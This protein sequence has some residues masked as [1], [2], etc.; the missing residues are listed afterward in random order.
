MRKS[1]I[2]FSIILI[3]LSFCGC[4]NNVGS[5]QP[6][7]SDDTMD[8]TN[9]TETAQTNISE[10]ETDPAN[11]MD[12]A[13]EQISVST[14]PVIAATNTPR[15]TA[16]VNPT[17]VATPQILEKQIS[18]GQTISTKY[19]DFTLNNVE[20]IYELKPVNTRGYYRYY[21]AD[22]GKI[23]IHID[24]VFY[25]TSKKD[26]CIEDLIVP[27]ANYNNGYKYEGFVVIDDGDRDFEWMSSCIA[28]TPLTSCHYHGLIE[29]PE[30]IESSAAS[31]YILLPMADGISYRYD[32]W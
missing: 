13:E 25:N 1:F 28:C 11:A 16:T 15:P 4:Q 7:M 21:S 14:E 5:K 27:K 18:T 19:Y 12:D 8:R 2:I 10:E 29:C 30:I 26:F 23:Y 24:G 31:L 3:V 22:N 9:Q 20:L 32:I 17:P 6:A